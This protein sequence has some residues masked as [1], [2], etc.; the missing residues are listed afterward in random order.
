MGQ[1]RDR[2]SLTYHPSMVRRFPLLPM[3]FGLFGAWALFGMLAAGNEKLNDLGAFAVAGGLG[4]LFALLVRPLLRVVK[5]AT[6]GRLGFGCMYGCLGVFFV[7][8]ITV[9]PALMMATD[10]AMRGLPGILGLLG[11]AGV[12]ILGG[13]TFHE[14]QRGEADRQQLALAREL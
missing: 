7:T 13:I 9:I 11:F 6:F 8:T 2:Y 14:F 1:L 12:G 3:L 4:A 5:P 10:A